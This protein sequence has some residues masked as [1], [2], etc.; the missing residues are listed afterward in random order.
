MTQPQ[1]PL[2]FAKFP[3]SIIGPGETMTFD[4]GL[5]DGV[6]V[7]AELGAV[8]ARRARDVHAQDALDH[9]FGYTCVNDV[10][11]RD[12]HFRDGQWVRAK[13]L[14]TFCRL[15]PWIVTAD[16][17]PDPQALLIGCTVSGTVLPSASAADM[18]FDVAELIA[19]LS[20]SFTL[21]PGDLLAT[22]TPPGVG[23]FRKPGRILRDGN[24][25]VVTIGQI[26]ELLSPVRATGGPAASTLVGP[27]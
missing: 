5:T 7:E 25:V 14:D 20:H 13:S 4:R 12:L 1:E 24:E 27:I 3:S 11:A 15:G 22:G 9:V 23:W 18:I 10:S 8:I 6:D 26:G 16:E 2:V 21:E 17:I 19:R